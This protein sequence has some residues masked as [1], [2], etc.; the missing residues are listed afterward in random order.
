M[1]MIA[2]GSGNGLRKVRLISSS[3]RPFVSNTLIALDSDSKNEKIPNAE[4]IS[5]LDPEYYLS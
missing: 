4:S 2:K 5:T 3:N 1:C